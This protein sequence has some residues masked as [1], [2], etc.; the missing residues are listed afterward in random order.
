MGLADL[1]RLR[2]KILDAGAFGTPKAEASEGKTHHSERGEGVTAT[3]R[4]NN[5][6]AGRF[7]A[8]RNGIMHCVNASFDTA[9]E[10]LDGV[11]HNPCSAA[12]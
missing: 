6:L 5:G 1:R 3:V 2:G 10:G 7:K 9:A 11:I 8:V 4:A 12:S